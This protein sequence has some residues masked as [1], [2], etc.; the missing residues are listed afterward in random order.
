MAYH[1]SRPIWTWRGEGSKQ[2]G[3]LSCGDR[4]GFEEISGE[5]AEV[6]MI[7]AI[8]IASQLTGFWLQAYDRGKPALWA[9]S[10]EA[11]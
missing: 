1:A 7:P 8:Q 2:V 4:G 5:K 9:P 6:R 3:D 11:H 10:L